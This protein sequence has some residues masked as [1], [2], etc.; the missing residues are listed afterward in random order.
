[1]SQ[2]RWPLHPRRVRHWDDARAG[3]ARGVAPRRKRAG[4]RAVTPKGWPPSQSRK[5]RR[6]RRAAASR[7]PVS[8]ALAATAAATADAAKGTMFGLCSSALRRRSTA[9]RDLPRARATSASRGSR[10]SGLVAIP[11]TAAGQARALRPARLV[12]AARAGAPSPPRPFEVGLYTLPH[13]QH[14][15]PAARRA[16][17][18]HRG[19]H[20]I[21]VAPKNQNNQTSNLARDLQSKTIKLGWPTR[22]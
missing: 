19:R 1:M 2:L 6:Q 11:V 21:S 16:P 14:R 8:Q 3:S 15:P 12:H 5:R 4:G 20:A 13:D 10:S 17:R 22:P 18:A 9:R 7:P